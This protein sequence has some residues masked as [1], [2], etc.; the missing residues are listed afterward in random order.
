MRICDCGLRLACYIS[1]RGGYH[2][3]SIEAI[4]NRQFLRWEQEQ[5]RRP[6]RNR[7]SFEPP[8]IVTVSRQTGSRGS[9]FASRLAQ[10]L[11]YQRLHREVIDAI[12]ESSGY[13]KRIVESLD[14]SLRSEIELMVEAVFTGQA[15]DH[16]DYSRHLCRVILS[17]AR[18]GGVVLVGRGGNFILGPKRGFHMRVICPM[19][20]R[21]TN[22]MEYKH[23]TRE[24]AEQEAADSDRRRR[25]FVRKLFDADID[26][27]QRYDLVLN[28][29]YIDV[30]EMVTTA[31]EAI[32]GK[33]DKLSHLDNDHHPDSDDNAATA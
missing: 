30:E 25:E 28:A 2:M 21:I 27:P 6:D 1:V 12:C 32:R 17:M 26:D 14:E 9:Y 23:L 19:H 11:G 20:R 18:L 10:K 22:L 5:S 4:I 7:T 33:A 3:T 24:D 15:V 16:S 31:I 29:A 13:R 8:P